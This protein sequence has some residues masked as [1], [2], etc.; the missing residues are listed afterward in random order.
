LIYSGRTTDEAYKIAVTEFHSLRE[1]QEKGQLSGNTP[2]IEL[3]SPVKS[4]PTGRSQVSMDERRRYPINDSSWTLE[5]KA[6]SANE[7][8]RRLRNQ[9]VGS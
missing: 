1:K 2:K 5:A 4:H 7:S 3:G 8:A 9:Y 6:L